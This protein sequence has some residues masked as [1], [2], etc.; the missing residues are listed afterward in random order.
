LRAPILTAPSP[1]SEADHVA[2]LALCL[3]PTVPPPL[4]GRPRRHEPL[5]SERSPEHRLA[6]F[7][8]GTL[9]PELPLPPHL[10]TGTRRPPEPPPR[11][12]TPPPSRFFHPS[13]RQEAPVSCRLHPL[14]RRV[15]SPPWMLE[16]LTLFHLRHGSAAASRAMKHARRVVTAP[17][18]ARAQ[19][20]AV[21]G[22]AGRG[23]PGKA[24]G[25][26]RCANGPHRHCGRG[27]CVT[28]QLGCARIRPSDS[29]INFSIF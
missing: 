3:Y 25:R 23:R 14:A 10:D 4:S 21:A 29:R 26:V 22:R 28:M 9:A 6:T 19:H 24:V 18:C 2:V 17:V 1:V 11:Q 20:H 16:R 7:L 27:P 12:R 15:A 8:S 13:H 5:H